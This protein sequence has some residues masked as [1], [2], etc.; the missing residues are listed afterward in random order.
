MEKRK[1]VFFIQVSRA[2]PNQRGMPCLMM[3]WVGGEPV[4]V[5]ML[6]RLVSSEKTDECCV[7][8]SDA[9]CDD[10][11]E[12]KLKESFPAHECV[13]CIRIKAGTD[14][15]FT[16]DHLRRNPFYPVTFLP[17]TGLYHL[18]CFFQ[19]YEM[20]PFETAI[21]C[22]ADMIPLMS[23]E[24]VDELLDQAKNRLCFYSW[25][26]HLP[27][28]AVMPYQEVREK[29]EEL[30]S[31][32]TQSRLFHQKKD[33]ER[34]FSTLWSVLGLIPKA[35]YISSFQ[36]LWRD[37]PVLNPFYCLHT[38]EEWQ[39]F[40][41]LFPLLEDAASRFSSLKSFLDSFSSESW[42]KSCLLFDDAVRKSEDEMGIRAT[43]WIQDIAEETGEEHYFMSVTDF[44]R[45]LDSFCR[46]PDLLT[47]G[48]FYEPV[49]HPDLPFFLEEA[50]R[51]HVLSGIKTSH[52]SLSENVMLDLISKGLGFIIL[53]L[54]FSAKEE[55]MHSCIEKL[56]RLKSSK[57]E[58]LIYLQ[59]TFSFDR[60]AWIRSLYELYEFRVDSIA[61]LPSKSRNHSPD[62]NPLDKKK[63]CGWSLNTVVSGARGQ[64]FLCE[65]NSGDSWEFTKENLSVLSKLRGYHNACISCYR[66]FRHNGSGERGS[67][68]V[69]TRPHPD[70]GLLLLALK[71]DME[72]RAEK[73]L[74]NNHIDSVRMFI[75]SMLEKQIICSSSLL[76]K[77]A[78]LFYHAGL[79]EEAFYYLELVLKQDPSSVKVHALLD[80]WEKEQTFSG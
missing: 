2:V 8:C 18:G 21:I 51:K 68:H 72:K 54:D 53:D 40:K 48:N 12:Q 66:K 52:F 15:A 41:L 32:I 25:G 3:E 80:Q 64:M 9:S 78:E 24:T 39:E 33:S 20:R 71:K 61:V 34:F 13:S 55:D 35:S 22:W 6:K 27:P 63:G 49:R 57:P 29:S 36:H 56:L 47:L 75:S 11:I 70:K 44:K 4:L 1:T 16:D 38:Q 42:E 76:I 37:S 30:R 45:C 7:V 28:L 60:E 58:F 73:A 77:S 19:V 74:E 62:L 59:I 43:H 50:G 46:A 65:E 17:L 14:G 26:V 10:I 69:M 31:E 5:K 79:P 23:G 67:E